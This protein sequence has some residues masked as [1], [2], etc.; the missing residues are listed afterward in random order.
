MTRTRS[1]ENLYKLAE[2][3]FAKSEGIIKWE[4][5]LCKSRADWT[6]EDKKG[7]M[8]IDKGKIMAVS[9]CYYSQDS[10]P[11]PKLPQILIQCQ[12][13]S[14]YYLNPPY[15]FGADNKL[16]RKG[17]EFVK[18]AAYNKARAMIKV[19]VEMI[20]NRPQELTDHQLQIIMEMAGRKIKMF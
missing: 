18:T 12:L 7:E 5:V 16:N 9:D 15:E 4:M 6:E 14:S 8:P 19:L 17:R 10:T 1:R 2:E 11:A 3:R 13:H 20:R